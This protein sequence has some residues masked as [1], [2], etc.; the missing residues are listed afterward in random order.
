M[1]PPHS[2]SDSH[3]VTRRYRKLS[4]SNNTFHKMHNISWTIFLKT[5][6]WLP[7]ILKSVTC[8]QAA[9]QKN[10]NWIV[11]LYP[12]HCLEVNPGGLC[13]QV[14][15]LISL[16]PSHDRVMRECLF[17]WRASESIQTNPLGSCITLTAKWLNNTTDRLSG[18]NFK[19]TKRQNNR[20]SQ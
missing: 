13:K 17:E 15:M 6:I 3:L 16:I 18:S 14:C 12:S 11:K 20:S 1:D 8:I 10:T 2:L 4:L 5:C 7:V 19:H 9:Q